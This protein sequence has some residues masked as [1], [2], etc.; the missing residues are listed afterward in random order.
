MGYSTKVVEMAM[1]GRTVD[2]HSASSNRY[3]N[4]RT[5]YD[6]AVANKIKKV[7]QTD[8]RHKDII[9][10]YTNGE[11]VECIILEPDGRK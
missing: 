3:F 1:D 10:T 2:V 8:K 4:C 5:L 6:L 9:V 11:F 7:E